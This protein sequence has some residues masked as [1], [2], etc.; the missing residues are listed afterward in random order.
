MLT[1]PASVTLTAAAAIA[2]AMVGTMADVCAAPVHPAAA[3]TPASAAPAAPPPRPRLYA[4]RGMAQ[5][6]DPAGVTNDTC[7]A[8]RMLPPT[9]PYLENTLAS[10]RA[11]FDAGADIVELD[12]H[13]TT[14][15]Q[16][17][18]FHDWTLDCRTE[19]RGVTREHSMAQL[20]A[21][22]VGHGYTADGGKT[23]P[24][25]GKGV[26]LMPSLDEVLATFADRALSINVKSNDPAEGVQLAA[27]LARLAPQRR[28]QLMVYGGDRPIAELRRLLPDLQTA[29]RAQLKSC[30]LRYMGYGWTGVVPQA[31]ERLALLLPINIAPWLWGWP[32]RLVD[33]MAA[34]GST[35]YLR[36]EYHGEAA[37][38]GIDTPADLARV[39]PG[40]RGG[41]W[42]D[43]IEAIAKAVKERAAPAPR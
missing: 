27:V 32:D 12:V 19:G 36:G 15:G 2:L 31:C 8:T 14:D 33:R 21:L 40:Y 1:L 13:P 24:F 43:E 29:S 42:T 9:H 18:V 3:S 6:F 39:P 7:T 34:A 10:M 11:A 38:G 30:L 22:D 35:I 23:F 17:A 4:H 41:L 28:R 26:G 20:K 5:Q 37:T 25:R 16:F